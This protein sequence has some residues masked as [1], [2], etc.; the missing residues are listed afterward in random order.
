MDEGGTTYQPFQISFPWY[1]KHLPVAFIKRLPKN[2]GNQ[3]A[4]DPMLGYFLLMTNT[5]PYG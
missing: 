3:G 2:A 4:T 5:F 1:I